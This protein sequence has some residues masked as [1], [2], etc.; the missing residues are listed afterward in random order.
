MHEVSLAEGVLQLIEDYRR[1]EG[2]SSVRLV[3]LEIGR[4]AEV[5]I[6]AMRFCFDSVVRGSVADG[7]VL[8]IVEVPGQG[9]CAICQR[10]VAMTAL[11][12]ACPDCG[13]FPLQVTG[14]R[15][16]RLSELEVE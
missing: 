1:A 14:G 9:W 10:T 5:E 3:Q 7:A 4:M 16:M 13:H 15:E 2:F 6:E 12:D 11:F 8:E